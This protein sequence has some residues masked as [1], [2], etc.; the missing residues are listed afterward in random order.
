MVSDPQH[1]LAT[2]RVSFLLAQ[3]GAFAAARFAERLEA[4][5]LQPSDIG[6]LRLIATEPGL[7]QQALADRLSVAPS[8]VVVLI[9]GLEKKGLVARERSVRDRRIYELRLTDE[10]RA[11]MGRMRHIGAAHEADMAKALTEEERDTLATLLNKIAASHEL[12]P[13]VHPGYRAAR[14]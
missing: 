8:R 2:S 11:V 1:P 14:G 5:A 4:L 13:N 9:D 10:G 12:T 7:S 3:V 6:I